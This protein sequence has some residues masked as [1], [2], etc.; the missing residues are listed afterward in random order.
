[1]THEL[2][3]ARADY[4]LDLEA[5]GVPLEDAIRETDEL[6]QKAPGVDPAVILQ[7]FVICHAFGVKG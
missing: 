2:A 4:I 7:H 6:M 5:Q 1:M 3:K